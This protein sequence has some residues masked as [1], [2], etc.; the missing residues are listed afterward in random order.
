MPFLNLMTRFDYLWMRVINKDYIYIYICIFEKAFCEA[1]LSLAC[2]VSSKPYLR[3]SCIPVWIQTHLQPSFSPASL[4]SANPQPAGLPPANL[5]A[6]C[7]IASS[8][9]LGLFAYSRLA[10]SQFSARDQTQVSE[11]A[12]FLS[13]VNSQVALQPA[14]HLPS[15][16]PESASH[17]DKSASMKPVSFLPDP[18][19]LWKEGRRKHGSHLYLA[20]ALS[21]APADISKAPGSASAKSAPV[22][23]F[24]IWP[25]WFLAEGCIL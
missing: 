14:N 6:S 23:W 19:L 22:L 3:N 10:P 12:V 13:W 9:H 18:A 1:G 11:L 17:V 15:P 20:S 25:I 7:P 16:A 2:G 24:S 5:L 8:L 4:Q 21:S